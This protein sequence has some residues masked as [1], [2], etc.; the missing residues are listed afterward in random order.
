MFRDSITAGSGTADIV[1][2]R[3]GSGASGSA[4]EPVSP[5]TGDPVNPALWII[6]GAVALAA[7]VFITARRRKGERQE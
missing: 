2:N 3:A 7:L 5:K 6:L 1:V 4:G